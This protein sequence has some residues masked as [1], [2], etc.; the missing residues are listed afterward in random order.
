MEI[1]NQ[2]FLISVYDTYYKNDVIYYFTN[3]LTILFVIFLIIFLFSKN[4]ER[5]QAIIRSV[6]PLL[7]SLGIFGTF[8][9]IFLGLI[10]F[11]TN[12]LNQSILLL[13]DGLKIAFFTSIV[14][15]AYSLAFR[16]V[17]L[18]SSLY[19]T[20]KR[21]AVKE[22]GVSAEDLLL[23]LS[24]IKDSI[25]GEQDSSLF[26]QIQK[27]RTDTT[28]NLKE[29]NS[30]FKEFAKEMSENNTK[31]LIEAIEQVMK[32]FN[33]KINEQI[34]DNFRRLNEGVEALV[35][36]QDNYKEQV[37]KM[38]EQFNIAGESIEKS[39]DSMTII[40]E[41]LENVPKITEQVKDILETNQNQISNLEGQLD[42]FSKM[43][44]NAVE[45]MPLIE[46]RLNEMTEAFQNSVSNQLESIKTVNEN[47]KTSIE[48]SNEA[49]KNSMYEQLATIKTV[50]EDTKSSIESSNEAIKS[51]IQSVVD[52]TSQ[53]LVQQIEALDKQM[54]EELS[55]ALELMGSKLTSLSN[56]FVKD[57]EPLT[58]QLS[59][60]VKSM[61][62]G[63]T[64]KNQEEQE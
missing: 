39:K 55:R 54:S 31:A 10:N 12:K 21:K 15:M 50:N 40:S 26:T 24:E 47:M 42:A 59:N 60:L 8:F 23:K 5:R 44:D 62:R 16:G 36:W 11:D 43:K 7:L 46:K 33:T 49:I 37:E 32:D 17:S 58:K 3:L 4:L 13:L 61:N 38:V 1:D 41:K 9:G 2:T 35:K 20:I 25:S 29:L 19:N 57:Y 14:G 6:P 56:Q 18:L 53:K 52:E 48:S 27:L 63:T 64:D 34:G 28:D 30:S 22:E 45:A 51:A